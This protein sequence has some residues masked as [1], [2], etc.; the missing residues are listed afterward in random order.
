[1]RKV[2]VAGVALLAMVVAPA[3]FIAP[4]SAASASVT[5]RNSYNYYCL[6]Q[7]HDT[8]G[9]PTT[10]VRMIADCRGEIGRQWTFQQSG[11]TFKVVNSRSGW[12]LSAPENSGS[13]VFAEVCV[14]GVAK[15][16]WGVTLTSYG[17]NLLAVQTPGRGCLYLR[18]ATDLAVTPNSQPEFCD[19]YQSWFNWHWS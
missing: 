5:V 13:K 12:C 15:Q 4:T 16:L 10:T 17:H 18:T 9:Q 14:P 11:A 1:M 2:I 19:G 7:L 8:A 3:W 6:D